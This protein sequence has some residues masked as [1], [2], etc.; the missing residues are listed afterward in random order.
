MKKE[1]NFPYPQIDP[2]YL[3]SFSKH[4]NIK[5]NS[6]AKPLKMNPSTLS[7]YYTGL[8]PSI[9]LNR[10]LYWYT[11]QTIDWKVIKTPT[12]YLRI[13]KNDFIKLTF[14]EDTMIVMPAIK[15]YEVYSEKAKNKTIVIDGCQ[16]N[17]LDLSNCHKCF[18]KIIN[19]NIKY[20]LVDEESDLKFNSN[21]TIE[22]IIKTALE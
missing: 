8:R 14:D 21:S 3:A 12:D 11:R 2:S 9:S 13:N 19:S 6:I 20:V 17:I 5:V 15:A 4:K 16:F 22:N 10:V 7:G 18:I 1:V